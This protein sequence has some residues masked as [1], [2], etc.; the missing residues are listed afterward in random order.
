MREPH[1]VAAVLV[2]RTNGGT[3]QLI[4][5]RVPSLVVRFLPT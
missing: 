5:E 2:E 4:G 1:A 3:D